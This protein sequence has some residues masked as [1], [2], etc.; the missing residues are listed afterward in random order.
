MARAAFAKPNQCPACLVTFTPD[1]E[2]I[3]IR[4]GDGHLCATHDALVVPDAIVWRGR[5]ADRPKS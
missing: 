3:A 5:W 2:V 1:A 4:H